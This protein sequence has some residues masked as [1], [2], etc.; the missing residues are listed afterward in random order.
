MIQTKHEQ[1]SQPWKILTM[2]ELWSRNVFSK[3]FPRKL[4]ASRSNPPRSGWTSGSERV[5]RHVGT[6][7]FYFLFSFDLT[8]T[9]TFLSVGDATN[10][11]ASR[12]GVWPPEIVKQVN[13]VKKKV[14]SSTV[15]N[16]RMKLPR[17]GRSG[18]VLRGN[19]YARTRPLLPE[20][21][22]VE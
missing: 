6:I 12:L 11:P 8:R 21:S 9:H 3:I 5:C 1:E 22:A 18:W 14:S 19:K 17:K 15:C 13:P 16:G 10:Q 20:P 7:I 4:K 2:N